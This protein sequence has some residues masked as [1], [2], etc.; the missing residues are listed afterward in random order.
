M[1]GEDPIGVE[2][3]DLFNQTPQKLTELSVLGLSDLDENGPKQFAGSIANVNV[4]QGNMSTDIQQLTKDLCTLEAELVNSDS[5]WQ[6]EGNVNERNEETW[7]LCNK[8]HTYRIAIPAP[9]DWNAAMQMCKTLGAGN[10]TELLDT[11]DLM[12]TVSLFK[13][14]NSPC[15]FIWT[16]VTDEKNEG[17]YK[18]AITRG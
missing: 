7:K 11:E 10:M 8:N 13:N 14:M 1:N 15:K 6:N 18:S 2:A 4:F 5:K 12:Y 9:I 3:K 16:P 17:E